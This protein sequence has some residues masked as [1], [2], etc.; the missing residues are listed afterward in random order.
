MPNGNWRWRTKGELVAVTI[1][2]CPKKSLSESEELHLLFLLC[3]L[4]SSIGLF[5]T[6]SCHLSKL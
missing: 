3:L 5:F 6:S 2:S 1:A 4:M